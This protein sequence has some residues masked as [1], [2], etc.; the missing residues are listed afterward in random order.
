MPQTGNK[1]TNRNT[2]LQQSGQK[3]QSATGL[4]R[5]TVIMLSTAIVLIILAI[6][7]A[8]IYPTYIGPFRISVITG[9]GIDVKMDYFIKRIKLSGSDPL[10]MLTQLTSDYVIKLGAG[11][12]GIA[13]DAQDING[14]IRSVFEGHSGNVTAGSDTEFKEWYRQLLNESGLTD[15]QYREIV[16]IEVLRARLQEYLAVRMPTQAEQIHLYGIFVE[17]QKDAEAIRARWAAGEK[18]GDLAKALSLDQMTAEK[19]GEIGWFPKGASLP[20]NFEYEAFNLATGNMSEPIPEVTDQQQP[21]G[22]SAPTVI[23]YH[24]LLVTEKSVRELDN[25]S[26]NILRGKVVEKWVE[27]ERHKYNITW[28][29]FKGA[30]DSETYAWIQYQIA[31]SKSSSSSSSSQQK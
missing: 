31:K 6:A 11:Q 1:K 28:H 3:L 8:F 4:T 14:A 20:P 12:Y 7:G 5:R 26:L 23:G 13:A 10:G 29:G 27:E 30:F 25:N 17:K 24:L 19:G 15:A 16:T 9:A 18:F 22:S 2:P 21:D